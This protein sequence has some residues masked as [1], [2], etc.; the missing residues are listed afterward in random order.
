MGKLAITG[1]KPVRKKP[2]SDWPIY[3]REEERAVQKVHLDSGL[4]L[5]RIRTMQQV[6]A[7]NMED[8]SLQTWL[9]GI[10]AALALVLAAVGVYGVMAYLVTQRT[11]EIGIR[12]ALGAQPRHV[13]S[14]VMGHG[15]RLAAIGA[16]AGAALA[17]ALSRLM[18]TLLFGV[19]PTDVPTFVSV[20][21]FLMGVALLA[22]Y[23]PARRAMKVDPVIALR[24]E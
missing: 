21:A 12:V 11:H 2:F 9:L 17:L 14:L 20:I 24:H 7:E 8:T 16:A 1:G 22:C 6:V 13:L 15:A 19:T 10:F 5:F 4:S 23:I 3:G 18:S